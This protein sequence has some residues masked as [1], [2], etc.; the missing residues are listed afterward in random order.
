[1][2]IYVCNT[3]CNSCMNVCSCVYVQR[4][5][6]EQVGLVGRT[7]G[8]KLSVGWV[9]VLNCCLTARPSAP[10]TPAEEEPTFAEQNMLLAMRLSH[11]TRSSARASAARRVSAPPP[12]LRFL[13]V[14]DDPRC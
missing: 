1:M 6:S 8:L 2:H 9:R 5:A 10:M 13:Q 14:P 7:P 12:A 4:C 11:P 3:T